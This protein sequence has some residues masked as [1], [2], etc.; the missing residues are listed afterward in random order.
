MKKSEILTTIL[1][2]LPI[3]FFILLVFQVFKGIFN[4][5]RPFYELAVPL[6]FTVGT[7][8]FAWILSK[9]HYPYIKHKVSRPLTMFF[10]P[11]TIIYSVLFETSFNYAR[12]LREPGSF[13]EH[14]QFHIFEDIY[15]F[16]AIL[17]AAWLA[18]IYRPTG[19]WPFIVSFIGGTIFHWWFAAGDGIQNLGSLF[20][21]LI[22][23]WLFYV[24]W[25]ITCF[26][27]IRK[28]AR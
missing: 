22:I 8:I 15:I 6:I 7:T 20:G 17:L 14:M 9:K 21:G 27:L 19:K 3:I 23:V 18:F 28:D 11:I 4:E 10:V 13:Y 25:Y 5:Q 26:I 16:L 12:F 1:W 24:T 2:I